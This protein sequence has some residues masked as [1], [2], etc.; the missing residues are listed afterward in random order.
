MAV[1]VLAGRPNKAAWASGERQEQQ[2]EWSVPSGC[3]GPHRGK[4]GHGVHPGIVFVCTASCHRV[5]PGDACGQLPYGTCPSC[6][7]VRQKLGIYGLGVTGHT[8]GRGWRSAMEGLNCVCQRT[9]AWG[10]CISAAPAL[11]GAGCPQS[12]VRAA[13]LAPR[14]WQKLSGLA[15]SCGWSP[16]CRGTAGAAAWE[17]GM[18]VPLPL[19]GVGAVRQAALAHLPLGARC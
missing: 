14:P 4:G 3:S 5:C 2:A 17:A 11:P 15:V 8:A 16:G 13:T 18:G 7:A 19:G 1:S 6:E 12:R 9:P 10:H